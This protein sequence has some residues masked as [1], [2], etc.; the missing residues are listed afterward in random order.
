MKS[1]P[2]FLRKAG[3][4]RRVRFFLYLSLKV[5]ECLLFTDVLSRISAFS[6]RV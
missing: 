3:L 1:L 6:A 4:T 5:R 2:V